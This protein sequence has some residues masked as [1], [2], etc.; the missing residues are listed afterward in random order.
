MNIEWLVYKF[1]FSYL[2]ALVFMVFLS[3]FNYFKTEL[4]K[5]YFTTL[6]FIFFTVSL[7]EP[8]LKDGLLSGGLTSGEITISAVLLGSAIS[9]LLCKRENKVNFYLVYG[10]INFFIFIFLCSSNFL[11][12]F[13]SIIFIFILYSMRPT[14]QTDK[15]TSFFKKS[16]YMSNKIC[17]CLFLFFMSMFY[18]STQ[19]LA[20]MDFDIHNHIIFT[21]ASMM[22]FL[23]SIAFLGLFPVYSFS[24]N[25]FNSLGSKNDWAFQ[26]FH[27][28]VIGIK[29]FS[30]SK[31]LFSYI[32]FSIAKQIEAFFIGLL[33]L[34][35]SLYI[36]K[37]FR[38]KILKKIILNYYL[39]NLSFIFLYIFL[40]DK[41][42]VD[43]NFFTYA[44]IF[45]FFNFNVIY[46]FLS[47]LILPVKNDVEILDLKGF[48]AQYRFM[49]IIFLILLFNFS[50]LPLFGG[51]WLKF[52]PLY[53]IFEGRALWLSL[54][55]LAIFLISIIPSVNIMRPVFLE[56]EKRQNFIINQSFNTE[57]LVYVLF[58]L[59]SGLFIFPLFYNFGGL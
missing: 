6:N 27:S 37:M 22:L 36:Y 52:V 32:E 56:T 50:G 39:L 4:S 9:S 43:S 28:L 49:A 54:I 21:V 23:C 46:Y 51:F 18:I 10:F 30:I 1:S 48:F 44:L 58:C 11:D 34:G 53:K 8:G 7:T 47:Q 55:T 20:F 31:N 45:N 12:L 33:I 26:S 35:S 25:F 3:F 17:L 57:S 13:I 40:A 5:T 38:T 14:D 15:T 59:V 42:S 24:Q 29:F 41:E 19:T 16:F 2:F